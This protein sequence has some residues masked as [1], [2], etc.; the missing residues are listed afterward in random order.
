MPRKF[1]L[2]AV[3]CAAA[4][5]LAASPVALAGGS[6]KNPTKAQ[7]KAAVAKARRS[8][9]L[10]AT[11]NVCNTH[12]HPHTIGIRGQ[13]PA[14]GFPARLTMLVVVDYW[15]KPHKRFLADPSARRLVE[16]GVVSYGYEQGG[17]TFKFQP[18]AGLFRGSVTFTWR[19]S[20]KV[21]LSVTR[22]TSAGHRT[23]DFGDPPGHSAAK[24]TIN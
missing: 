11:I 21:L 1:L 9:H 24:C 16:L 23:A 12:K 8:G 2:S 7:I 5:V 19:R 18:H 17:R 22:T 14:L 13:M 15:D 10:W 6:S 4:A 20:G 3:L